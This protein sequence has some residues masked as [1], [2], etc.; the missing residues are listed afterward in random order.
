[1]GV[2]GASYPVVLTNCHDL[3][4]TQW[5]GGI[6][7]DAN[8]YHIIRNNSGGGERPAVTRL[9]ASEITSYGGVAQFRGQIESVA[10]FGTNE[11]INVLPNGDFIRWD[12]P[13]PFV[14]TIPTGTTYWEGTVV[15]CGDGQ[16]DTTRTYHS[17]NC[18]KVSSIDGYSYGWTLFWDIP[19]SISQHLLNCDVTLS[20]KAKHV[21]GTNIY[22]NL[23]YSVA[24]Q[25]D[26]Q[27]TFLG[28]DMPCENGFR[29]HSMSIRISQAM[30]DYGLRLAIAGY[31]D[32]VYYISE[33]SLSI[34]SIA[35]R[36]FNRCSTRPGVPGE[37]KPNG[38][39]V[40]YTSA[41]PVTY[42][43]PLFNKPWHDGDIA[44]LTN[45]TIT[46]G[47]IQTGWIRD[48]YATWAPLLSSQDVANIASLRA[49]IDLVL[50][51]SCNLVCHTTA[52]F[53]GGSFYWDGYST[54]ADDNGSI[55]QVTGITTG[56]WK[57]K[58]N[59]LVDVRSYGAVPGS[60][61]C[62]AAIQAA[63]NYVNSD[64]LSTG[65]Y[66][67]SGVWKV[68]GMLTLGANQKLEL[69]QACTLKRY[70]TSSNVT[71]IVWIKGTGASLIGGGDSSI[72]KT[73]KACSSGIV[74]LGYEST[75]GQVPAAHIV[76]ASIKGV[77]L[78]G[79]QLYG[80]PTGSPD[81]GIYMVSAQVDSPSYVS[82]FHR[83]SDISCN[84]VN[85]AI[86]LCG[87]AN[88]NFINNIYG[89]YLGN[90]LIFLN[91]GLDNQISNLFLNSSSEANVILLQDIT[92][93]A[94]TYK[95]QYNIVSG[96]G[97][98]PG[99]LNSATIRATAP[100]TGNGNILQC[101]INT[102]QGCPVTS[103]FYDNGN[104]IISDIGIDIRDI[105]AHG[106]GKLN[107]L[108]NQHTIVPRQDLTI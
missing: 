69:S 47:V 9:N 22:G 51:K 46:N 79:M 27:W 96:I 40:T 62:T 71:P 87:W 19:V 105:V 29:F 65:A 61:D 86:W 4:F 67:P 1:M 37:I 48:G 34:G 68:D 95:S 98:E 41:I 53:G 21:S 17:P 66:V 54:D 104:A 107:T 97:G 10:G 20:F 99:G 18:L 56:R 7:T 45:P 76:Q 59:G 15:K 101:S 2:G 77:R 57:R 25:N 42:N 63:I 89:G 103:D 44:L 8:C 3:E 39:L 81:V 82:Y 78:D 70:S 24:G 38:S 33:L 49:R 32:A 94:V 73:E 26:L 60:T 12:D 14:P 11:P 31:Q 35:P 102:N 5:L 93:G 43:D 100:F 90:S 74:R 52:G 55:I 36:T 28:G 50:L 84:Q 106:T 13:T 30:V 72:L 88:G 6:K 80:Q 23:G 75:T 64:G 58:I 91:G 108:V 83:I 16:S 85:H 92:I